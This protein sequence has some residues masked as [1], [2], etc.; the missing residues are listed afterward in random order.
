MALTY[1]V[2]NN[3][4]YLEEYTQTDAQKWM[5]DRYQRDIVLEGLIYDNNSVAKE[6]KTEYILLL[7]V[8]CC[9][10]VLSRYC[11]HGEPEQL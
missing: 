4:V 2:E 7:V 9:F 6:I 8:L 11:M 3:Q 10:A 5:I 1:D